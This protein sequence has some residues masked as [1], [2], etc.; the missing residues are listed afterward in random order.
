MTLELPLHDL[1]TADPNSEPF[2][3]HAPS[4]AICAVAAG[5]E[6]SRRSEIWKAFATRHA[7]LLTKGTLQDLHV[8]DH[9]SRLVDFV[10]HNHTLY[11]RARGHQGRELHNI[12]KKERNK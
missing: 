5:K 4:D 9:Q 2:D 3:A 11:R 12:T 7:D 10:I 1:L 8:V 6:L